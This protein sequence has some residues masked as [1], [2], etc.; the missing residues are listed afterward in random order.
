M[1]NQSVT[2]VDFV[3]TATCFRILFC[4]LHVV[5][6]C[7]LFYMHPTNPYS[8]LCIAL[9]NLLILTLNLTPKTYTNTNSLIYLTNQQQQPE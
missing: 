2:D 1:Q 4:T 7:M 8:A 6:L 5:V 3:S 9:C